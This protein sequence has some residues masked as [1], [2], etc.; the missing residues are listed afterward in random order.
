M[1]SHRNILECQTDEWR[2]C[3][4]QIEYYSATLKKAILL[5]VIALYPQGLPVLSEMSYRE[6]DKYYMIS[7]NVET[8]KATHWNRLDLL[9]ADVVL[10]VKEF[11]K[12]AQN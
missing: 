5:F 3:G 8:K 11:S 9:L 2:D 12:D 7:L 6:K 4:T 10:G 1:T